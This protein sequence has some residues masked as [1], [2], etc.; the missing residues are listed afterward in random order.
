M[1]VGRSFRAGEDFERRLRALVAERY[2]ALGCPV[3]VGVDLGHTDP[4]LTLP[5][6]VRVRLDAGRR[7]FEVVDGA[8]R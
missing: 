3:L 5:I 1:V 7:V 4:M 2:T 8:V 6:G